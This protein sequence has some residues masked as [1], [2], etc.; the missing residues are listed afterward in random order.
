MH[1]CHLISQLMAY[2]HDWIELTTKKKP[3]LPSLII[4]LLLKKQKKKQETLSAAMS[5]NQNQDTA[6]FSA[7]DVHSD[8]C[9]P[10][11]FIHNRTLE[12]CSGLHNQTGWWFNQCD[13][14][15]LNGSPEDVEQKPPLKTHILWDTWRQNGSPRVI[16]SVT[17]KIRRIV[18]NN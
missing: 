1:L 11:C 8:G 10:S 15:N 2:K 6:P 13:L 16:R 12:S 9:N 4:V 7:L 18:T 17:M 14:A 5:R 3:F